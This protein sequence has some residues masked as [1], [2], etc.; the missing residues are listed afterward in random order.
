MNN[1][2]DLRYLWLFLV[3]LI[4]HLV[5]YM[6]CYIY[7]IYLLQTHNQTIILNPSA[8]QED[9]SA[10]CLTKCHNQKTHKTQ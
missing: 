6:P 4:L 1:K 9:K 10:K 5:E 7:I 3:L 8:T 2:S